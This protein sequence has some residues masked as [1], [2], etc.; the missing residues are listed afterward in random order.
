MKTCLIMGLRPV[1]VRRKYPEGAAEVFNHRSISSQIVLKWLLKL[2]LMA[3]FETDRAIGLDWS[4]D[5][6]YLAVVRGL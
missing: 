2:R 4:R 1:S 6:R 3:E 5:S